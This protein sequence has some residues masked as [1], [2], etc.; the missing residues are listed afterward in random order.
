MVDDRI[1]CGQIFFLSHLKSIALVCE[2]CGQ[3]DYCTLEE[4]RDHI[5]YHFPESDDEVYIISDSDCES[6]PQ[7]NPDVTEAQLAST[8]QNVDCSLQKT[9]ASENLLIER[10]WVPSSS[11]N[12]LNDDNE[13]NQHR[14]KHT[15]RALTMPSTHFNGNHNIP[16]TNVE[17][18]LPL[19]SK[20]SKQLRTKTFIICNEVA[21]GLN[22]LQEQ[23][24]ITSEIHCNRTKKSFECKFCHKLLT[25]STSRHDHE[26]R[27]TGNRPHKCQICSKA[28][29]STSA[30][31]SHVKLMH[32]RDYRHACSL[33][34]KRFFYP[35]RLDNHIRESHLPDNDPRRYFQ[36][37]QCDKKFKRILLLRSH[38]SRDH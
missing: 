7:D 18:G 27:H 15:K 28:F 6:V 33:C 31:F 21:A 9:D 26:N 2:F 12:E 16:E 8:H 24:S 22:G 4:F 20:R 3:D 23:N 10:E 11:E 37:K 19:S 14:R 34:D 1:K 25:S 5:K 35:N 32:R 38:M 29:A 30:V 36:C 17:N 13:T